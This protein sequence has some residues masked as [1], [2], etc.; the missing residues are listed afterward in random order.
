MGKKFSLFGPH[1]SNFEE[2]RKKRFLFILASFHSSVLKS[3]RGD[4]PIEEVFSFGMKLGRFGPLPEVPCG[5]A[6]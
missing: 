2:K 6:L 1:F 4:H 3:S 5:R